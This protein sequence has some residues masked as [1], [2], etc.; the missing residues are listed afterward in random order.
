MGGPGRKL[1]PTERPRRHAGTGLLVSRNLLRSGHTYLQFGELATKILHG[2]PAGTGPPATECLREAA[3]YRRVA[4]QTH[5]SL[6]IHTFE[7]RSPQRKERLR[8]GQLT[9]R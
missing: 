1:L 7:A 3:S 2:N 9:I 6:R 8:I 5:G 4:R